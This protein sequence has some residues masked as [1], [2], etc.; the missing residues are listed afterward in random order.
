MSATRRDFVIGAAALAAVPVSAGAAGRRRRVG[1]VGGGIIGASVAFQLAR[2]GAEVILFEREAP[3]ARATRASVAW[4]NPVVND[5]AY[6]RLR[7]ESMRAW[8]EDDRALGMNA[9]WGGSIS[10]AYPDKEEALR[11]K[12]AVLQHTDDPPRALT[13]RQ[14]T[15]VSRGIHA[16][17]DVAFAFETRRDGHVDPVQATRRYLAAAKKLG[18]RILYPCEVEGIV[19]ASGRMTHVETSRG[20]WA[21]DDIVSVAGVDTPRIMAMMDRTLELAHKP[22]LVV[23]TEARPVVTDKVFEA[24]SVIEFKQYADGRFLTSLTGGPPELPVHAAIRQQRAAFPD[25]ELRRRHG[26]MLIDQTATYLPAM[27]GTRPAQVLLGFRPYPLDNRPICGPVPG[28]EGAYLVVTHSGL[29]L[30][31]I[32]GRYV[33]QEIMEKTPAALLT[34]Y[35]PSRFMKV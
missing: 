16:G 30:A 29:T 3:A 10:W 19:V 24:S 18:A 32:L 31:P 20:R 27:A 26:Q 28:V 7:L 33:A 14:I 4:I 21:L 6:M 8:R 34:P 9:I 23:H 2:A 1:V 5:A 22:G 15:E 35:R 11:A 12:A 17:D 25:D 13:S